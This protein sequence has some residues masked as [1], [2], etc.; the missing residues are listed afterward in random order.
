MEIDFCD[1]KIG[2]REKVGEWLIILGKTL[3]DI[4]K[5]SLTNIQ[6]EIKVYGE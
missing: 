5:Q 6:K 1:V 2:A 3:T 4:A